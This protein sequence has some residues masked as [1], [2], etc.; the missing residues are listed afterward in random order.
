[1]AHS[2]RAVVS[3]LDFGFGFFVDFVFTPSR[4]VLVGPFEAF[5]GAAFYYLVLLTLFSVLQSRVE[6]RLGAH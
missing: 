5:L 6:R 1:M 2:I 3:A 4:A